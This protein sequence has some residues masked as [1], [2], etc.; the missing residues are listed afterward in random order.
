[1]YMYASARYVFIG[2]IACHVFI[3]YVYIYIC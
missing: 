3:G 2:Y 1:M